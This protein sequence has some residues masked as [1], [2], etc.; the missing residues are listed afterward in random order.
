MIN[1]SG[2]TQIYTPPVNPRGS[3]DAHRHVM[4]IWSKNTRR[5]D[6]WNKGQRDVRR[7]DAILVASVPLKVAAPRRCVCLA[8]SSFI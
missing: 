8:N 6:Y 2:L 5:D 3:T 1:A 7:E 4:C